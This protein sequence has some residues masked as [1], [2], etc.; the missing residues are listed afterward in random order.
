VKP[1]VGGRLAV[2]RKTAR[3]ED[4]VLNGDADPDDRV[5]HVW[6]AAAASLVN[7]GQAA[8][9]LVLGDATATACG[10]RHLVAIRTA[11]LLMCPALSSTGL[12]WVIQAT[13]AAHC[14]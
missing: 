6:D 1:D 13:D 7:V 14:P 4:D 2:G 5:A 8:E 3:A 9:E 10:P 12:R 11:P